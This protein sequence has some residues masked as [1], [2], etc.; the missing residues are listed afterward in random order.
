MIQAAHELFRIRDPSDVGAARRAIDTL[1]GRLGIAEQPSAS[2]Q[3]AATELGTN[4]LRHGKD[5]YLLLR[6]LEAGGE[7][8]LEILAVDQGQ[9]MAD[10]SAAPGGA[11]ARSDGLGVG[12]G[13][14]QRLATSFDLYT[15]AASGTVVLGRF[16]SGR[17]TDEVAEAG[18]LRSGGVSVAAVPADPNGDGWAVTHDQAGCV[19][20][21]VDGLGHGPL[22]HQAA[23]AAL[24]AFTADDDSDPCS[25]LCQAHAAMRH[26]RGGVATVACI[27]PFQR[28]VRF[29]GV[30]NIQGK[31]VAAGQARGLASQPGMLGA[32]AQLPRLRLTNLP[33]TPGATLLLWSDGLR[34]QV[35][36]TADATLLTH[37]P[38]VVAAALHRDFARGSDDATIVVVQDQIGQRWLHT[39]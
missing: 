20:L 35:T 27:E 33:W 26:T 18:A 19:V 17:C 38:T 9:G 29:A 15:E 13:A 14:V 36:L 34:S 1:A 21:V 4:I 28:R 8:A 11:A 12:L 6:S 37:D 23:Q 16:G 10:P 7:R 25:R 30:G 22:A 5:G 24:A 39:S 3:L 2:A 31:I 32:G